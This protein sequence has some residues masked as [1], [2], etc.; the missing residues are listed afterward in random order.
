VTTPRGTS[1][2]SDPRRLGGDIAG[3]GGPRDRDSVVFDTT[4]AVILDSTVVAVMHN[5][6]DG[7]DVVGVLLEGRINRST[8]RTRVLFLTD[9]D[10]LAT[11][12][13]E[14][15]SLAKRA[16]DGGMRELAADIAVALDV[17]QTALQA[18]GLL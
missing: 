13:T 17:R 12:I 9:G 11:L 1:G 2:A 3:P 7:R 15:L 16:A 8:D 18:E 6:S 4:N 10:G 14:G 5:P